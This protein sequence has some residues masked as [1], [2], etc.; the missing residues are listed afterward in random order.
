MR[1][2][3]GGQEQ[4]MPVS[5]SRIAIAAAAAVAVGLVATWSVTRKGAGDAFAHCGGAQVAGG[6]AVIGGPFTLTN[7][8][9]KRVTD[10]DVLTKP[11][12]VYFG[13]TNCPDVCP[14]DM[15]RNAQ[16]I[17]IL[18]EQGDDVT[19]VFI[20]VD[21][22]RDTPAVLKQWTGYLHPK[23]IGL[24]GTPDELKAV[25]MEYKTYFQVPDSP[26]DQDYEVQHM[27]QTYLMMPGTGFADFFGRDDTAD[28]VAERTACYVEAAKGTN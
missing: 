16:A 18:E 5:S 4:D 9:G 23:M 10:K 8:D 11:S 7:A 14:T 26:A 20:S 17:D 28:K 24:T 12:L 22:R 21:P 13:Y 25:A 1:P 3:V 19:P 15:A 2:I 27:T 6:G